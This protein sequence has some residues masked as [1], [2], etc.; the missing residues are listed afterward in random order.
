MTNTLVTSAVFVC[1]LCLFGPSVN[2]LPAAASTAVCNSVLQCVT[3]CYSAAGLTRCL[4]DVP[5]TCVF[6]YVSSSVGMRS[7]GNVMGPVT[8]GRWNAISVCVPWRGVGVLGVGGSISMSFQHT[9]R[10]FLT[11][12]LSW[13]EEKQKVTGGVHTA[14]ATVM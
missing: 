14:A 2:L 7:L 10:T 4:Q 12:T 1:V 13:Y 5:T 8:G 6:A 9:L 3:V 11:T